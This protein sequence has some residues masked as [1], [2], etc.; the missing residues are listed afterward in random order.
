[1][2]RN[3][4]RGDPGGQTY[5]AQRVRPAAGQLIWMIDE[6]AAALL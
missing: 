2:L 6:A 4:L 3:V 1:M 5:P